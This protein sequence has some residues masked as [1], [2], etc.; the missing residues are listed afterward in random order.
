VPI[1]PMQTFLDR[2]TE[3]IR[4]AERR[5]NDRRLQ[6]AIVGGGVAGTEVA[7][8]LPAFIASRTKLG[9]E[10]HLLSK[11]DSILPELTEST[12]KRL[13]AEISTLSSG[14][15]ARRLLNCWANWTSTSIPV[16]SWPPMMRCNRHPSAV[17]LP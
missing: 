14:R 16:V 9:I 12:R 2:L 5:R 3:A 11:S 8:C 4:V 10:I 6:V 13:A 15:P 17:C 1:K 7:L